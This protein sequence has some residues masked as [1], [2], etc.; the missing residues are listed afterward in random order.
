MLLLVRGILL[1]PAVPV[2][3]VVWLVA[4]LRFGARRVSPAQALGFLDL[5]LAACIERTV[6]RPFVRQPHPFVAVGTLPDV[7]HRVSLSDLS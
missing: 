4:P 3:G 5:N 7:A 2:A 1:W 6:L